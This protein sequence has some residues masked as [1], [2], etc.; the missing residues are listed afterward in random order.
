M[1]NSVRASSPQSYMSTS[2]KIVLS[3]RPRST[4]RIT[5]EQHRLLSITATRAKYTQLKEPRMPIAEMLSGRFFL[6]SP[7]HANY[8]YD[9]VSPLETKALHIFHNTFHKR[10]S[11]DHFCC[12]DHVIFASTFFVLG[13]FKAEVSS[14]PPTK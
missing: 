9:T 4:R 10:L 1:R 3:F 13:K 7:P 2:S 6:L 8:Y 5:K 12:C 11:A 14:T